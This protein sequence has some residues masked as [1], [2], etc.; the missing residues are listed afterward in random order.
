M[1]IGLFFGSFNPVHTGHMIISNYVLEF[2]GLDQIWLIV[3]PQN[4]FKESSSLLN[5]YHRLALVKLAIEAEPNLRASDIEF[6]LPRPSYTID[7]LAYLKEKYPS[8]SFALIIGADSLQ[9]LP[10][11]KNGEK[12]LTGHEIYVYRRLGFESTDLYKDR[13]N[14]HF[15]NSPIIEISSTEIRKKI[16]EGKSIHWL[17]PDP[18]KEEIE[19]GGYYK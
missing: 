18:V 15:L 5:E 19:K 14:I 8:H 2:T 1:K 10:Q 9:N 6:Q 11:W 7:T 17:V 16:R 13:P 12:I 3:S 4:P